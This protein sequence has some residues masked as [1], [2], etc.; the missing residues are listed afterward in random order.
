MLNACK[1]AAARL[2]RYVAACFSMAADDARAE[3]LERRAMLSTTTATAASA[4][5]SAAAYDASGNLHVAYYDAIAQNLK[6]AVQSAGG[7]WS[8]PATLDASSADAGRFPAL[9][10]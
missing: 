8:G 3:A 1:A 4:G 9:A 10:I 5:E 7:A 6:Y 2:S